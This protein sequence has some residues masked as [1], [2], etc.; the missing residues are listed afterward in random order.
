MRH[1][2]ILLFSVPCALLAQRNKELQFRVG[3]GI[4]GY[5]TMSDYTLKFGNAE[6]QFKDTSGAATRQ[7]HLGVRYEVHHRIALGL[8][9]RRGNYIY[10]PEEDNKGKENSFGMFGLTA[11]LN[12]ISRPQFRWNLGL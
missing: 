11:E 9:F 5:A 4:A 12:M 6:Y 3:T 1:L 2:F 8:D 7:L 10:D